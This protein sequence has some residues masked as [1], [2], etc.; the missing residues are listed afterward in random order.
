M[1][2]RDVFSLFLVSILLC[3]GQAIAQ[4]SPNFSYGQVPTA[5]QWNAA[6]A[7]KQDVL[8]FTPLNVSGGTM[9]GKLS[10]APAT[11]SQSGFAL[12]PGIAPT[13][14]NNGDLWA[15]SSGVF[16]RIG[17]QTVQ[18]ANA[19]NLGTIASQNSNSVNI[20]G[21]SINGTAIGGTSPASGAFSTLIAA[22]PLPISSG[23]TG[24][25]S[26]PAA[27]SAL[28]AAASGANADITSLSSPALGS[29]TMVTQTAGDNSTKG[30][31]TAFVNAAVSATS[32]IQPN[33][34]VLTVSGG[35]LIFKPLRGNLVMVGGVLRTIPSGGVPLA[36]TGQTVGTLYYDYL[37]WTGS[38]L[39]IEAST[40]SY[41][42]DVATGTMVKS[43]DATRTLIGMHVP[44]TGPAVTLSQ[45]RSWFNDP[46][47]TIQV[48][49][50]ATFQS[51]DGSA[52]VPSSPPAGFIATFLVWAGEALKVNFTSSGLGT[53]NATNYAT[54]FVLDGAVVTDRGVAATT[55][56]NT[57][58]RQVAM[59]AIWP[60]PTEG[61]HTLTVIG[62]NIA[63]S[64]T[65]LNYTFA[66]D[67][68]VPTM[69]IITRKTV[70]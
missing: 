66:T 1:P 24:A 33:S 43:G 22:T 65:R 52:W 18:F 59:N 12:L 30:A 3:H 2:P 51:S 42:I 23:G 19:G 4:S 63:N 44:I 31:T 38:A 16:A 32:G 53:G 58:Y 9:L 46:G 10:T 8:N 21:G 25:G 64:G 49:A 40:T 54:A 6:F 57:A 17:G 61:S 69:T 70:Q 62:R 37:Y 60:S 45:V 39:A 29:P 5:G 34:G 47:Q 14:P 55:A 41:A 28:G 56:D 67:T 7:S 15:T 20:T 27:R 13:S 11:V 36:P 35:N 26:A 48:A 68:A 50:T